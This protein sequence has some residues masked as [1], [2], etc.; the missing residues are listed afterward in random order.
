MIQ[1]FVTETLDPVIDIGLRRGEV[2]ESI[3]AIVD[4]GFSGH[5]CLSKQ[6]EGKIELVFHHVERYELANIPGALSK[7]RGGS[8]LHP[9][10][11]GKNENSANLRHHRPGRKLP[12]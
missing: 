7:S 10:E 2:T 12:R 3:S 8:E 6:H 5:L 11:K 1:G 4:T 9:E